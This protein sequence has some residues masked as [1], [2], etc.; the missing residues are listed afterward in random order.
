MINV[1]HS[2]ANQVLDA[3]HDITHAYRSQMRARMQEQDANLTRGALR[4]LLYVGH[5]PRCTHKDLMAYLHADK[6]Q[7]ARTLSEMEDNQWMERVPDPE[8]RRSRLLQLSPRGCE[9]YARMRASRSKVGEDLLRECSEDQ[10]AQL[11]ALLTQVCA[12]LKP[13]SDGG[14]GG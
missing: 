8:D 9:L 10:Q 4:C 11:L 3:L 7:I 1:N 14:C 13:V 12:G 2:T 6:A 5:H